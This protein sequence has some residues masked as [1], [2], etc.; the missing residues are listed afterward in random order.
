M[1]GKMEQ[2][3]LITLTADI[4]SAHLSNNRVPMDQVGGL[5][6]QVHQALASL[7]NA[8]EAQQPVD[9]V[10]VVSIRASIKPDYIVCMECG[11]KQKTLKR[12]LQTAHGLSPRQYRTDFGLPESYPMTAPEYSERRKEM[13]KSIGLGRKKGET[14]QATK[15]KTQTN[16]PKAPRKKASTAPAAA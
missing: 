13:A 15:T 9:K 12:H 1:G 2:N 4:V 7:G 5:V 11:K 3:E 6:Q 16:G 8:P 10:P 14:K